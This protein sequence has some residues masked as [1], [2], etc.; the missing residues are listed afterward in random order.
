[1]EAGD[2]GEAWQSIKEKAPMNA[3]TLL[4]SQERPSI[5]CSARQA[6]SSNSSA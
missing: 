4:G 2:R 3:D 5:T 6:V 1:M